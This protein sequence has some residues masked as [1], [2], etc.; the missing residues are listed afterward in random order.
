MNTRTLN[1]RG[2]H[3]EQH[4]QLEPEPQGVAF[5]QSAFGGSIG[6]MA[7]VMAKGTEV[8]EEFYYA[9]GLTALGALCTGRL[10][11]AANVEC[12]PRLFT[13][14]LGESADVKK[15]TALRR[16]VSLFKPFF[17]PMPMLAGKSVKVLHGVASAEGLGRMLNEHNH[18]LLCYDEMKALMDKASIK[19][20]TLLAMTASL[21]EG[22]TWSNATKNPKQ[23]IEVDDGHLSLLGCCTT[24]TYARMWTSDAI[25]IG[26]PNRLFIVG[27]DRKR[28]VAWPESPDQ[29]DVDAVLEWIKEQL[30]TLPRRYQITPKAKTR[31]EEWYEQIPSSEHAKRLDAIGFRLMGLLALTN[32]KNEID[33]GTIDTLLA[34]LDYEI[35]IR[36]LTDPIDADDH[37]A[38]LEQKILRVLGVRGRLSRRDLQRHTN[39]QR[40]GLW[41]FEKAISH[42]M[43]EKYMRLDDD[44]AYSLAE[45]EQ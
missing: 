19:S 44:A 3:N 37:I 25:S 36:K 39:A 27:A 29:E 6:A 2:G 18:A 15:S 45:G 11:V 34:V 13:V 16:T 31:W 43:R 5:P 35:K 32:D 20:S 24:E 1:D 30:A 42:L 26:L 21:F 10:R 17:D 14:L 7:Y 12:E 38:K 33:A 23:S 28:K 8:P 4:S 22:T 40:A 41:A 9:A